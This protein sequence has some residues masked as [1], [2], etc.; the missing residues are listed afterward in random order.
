MTKVTKDP[1]PDPECLGRWARVNPVE[2][3][4]RRYL[5]GGDANGMASRYT[6]AVAEQKDSEE[7]RK[8]NSAGGRRKGEGRSRETR[9]ERERETK[10]QGKDEEE[11]EE[12]EQEGGSGK[13][14][15]RTEG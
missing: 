11:K 3:Q 4:K 9:R 15:E 12:K 5:F 10:V 8:S 14:S 7:R 2:L 6:L 13:G 1:S